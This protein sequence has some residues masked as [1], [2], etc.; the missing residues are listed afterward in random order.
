MNII[1]GHIVILFPGDN[2]LTALSVAR[3]CHMVKENDHV[4]LV[5]ALPPQ[6]DKFGDSISPPSIEYIYTDQT[7]DTSPITSK[8]FNVRAVY[9]YKFLLLKLLAM[10]YFKVR[11]M[12]PASPLA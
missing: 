10:L 7:A 2:M 1:H 3:E 9:R 5:Q 4:I 8:S 12:P 11:D 6:T